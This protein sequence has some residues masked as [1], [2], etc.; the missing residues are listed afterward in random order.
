MLPVL[1]ILAYLFYR[2]QQF[3]RPQDFASDDYS[4]PL[5]QR[6]TRFWPVCIAFPSLLDEVVM[7]IPYR[8]VGRCKAYLV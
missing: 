8:V 1:T 7:Q 6:D 4:K 2:E 5:C 3:S